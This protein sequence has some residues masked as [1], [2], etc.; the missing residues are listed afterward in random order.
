MLALL[1]HWSVLR[2]SSCPIGTLL[3]DTQIR[4]LSDG[5]PTSY[6][7]IDNTPSERDA[8][9]I[10]MTAASAEETT[11]GQGRQASEFQHPLFSACRYIDERYED[12]KSEQSARRLL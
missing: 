9:I 12:D 10:S 5:L 11:R 2:M 8:M 4:L 3:L 1:R 6:D 7:R